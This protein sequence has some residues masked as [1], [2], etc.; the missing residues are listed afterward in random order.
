MFQLRG[1]FLGESADHET[2]GTV[3]IRLGTA[4][5]GYSASIKITVESSTV[6]ASKIPPLERITYCRASWLSL[7]LC[8]L[9]G[10]ITLEGSNPRRAM[11]AIRESNIEFEVEYVV[12]GVEVEARDVGYAIF[13]CAIANA[14]HPSKSSSFVAPEESR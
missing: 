7:G 3:F 8:T 9:F 10:T 12:K 13:I 4:V 5:S 11:A 1:V 2:L 14:A 6:L